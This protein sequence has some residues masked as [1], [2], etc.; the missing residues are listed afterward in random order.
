[1]LYASTDGTGAENVLICVLGAV[2]TYG[3]AS[4]PEMALIMKSL[5]FEVVIERE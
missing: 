1:M 3:P 4:G 5:A 2:G